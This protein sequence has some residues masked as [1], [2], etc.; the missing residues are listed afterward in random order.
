MQEQKIGIKQLFASDDQS[1]LIIRNQSDII[2]GIKD[3]TLALLERAFRFCRRSP[4]TDML[5]ERR[6]FMLT[7]YQYLV[8][9]DADQYR[10]QL[11][12]LIGGSP[13]RHSN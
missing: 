1:P 12:K 5:W 2:G 9:I 6:S 10:Q 3:E 4:T 7:K 13:T 11:D 8:N